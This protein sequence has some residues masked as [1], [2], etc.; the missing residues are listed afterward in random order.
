MEFN[1][2][3]WFEIPVTDMERA[4]KFYTE[5]L[6]YELSDQKMGSMK[7]AW[8]PMDDR[9]DPEAKPQV[10]FWAV[11]CAARFVCANR[12]VVLHSACFVRLVVSG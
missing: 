5:L 2:V 8:F 12:K 1:P 3:G 9:N 10:R 7:M 4:K 11:G 6:G